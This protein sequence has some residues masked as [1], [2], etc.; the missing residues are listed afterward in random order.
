MKDSLQ[1]SLWRTCRALANYRR[2][3]LL[4]ILDQR[5][6]TTVSQ[7]AE[8]TGRPV[9]EISQGLRAL[10]ARGLL[11]VR[12]HW[13]NVYYRAGGDPTVPWA[14]EL[15]RA[16]TP[17]LRDG[18]DGML[19][20]FSALTSFTHYRRQQI[21]WALDEGRVLAELQR[22]VGASRPALR[23]HLRKLR[24]RGMVDYKRGLYRKAQPPDRLR[25]TMMSL[26][27]KHDETS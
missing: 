2:L 19:L 16:I 24:T 8:L 6:E 5:G 25:Q 1:P 26:A 11:K 17:V 9:S 13:R 23:R 22:K 14:A 15:L 18:E 10:N 7:M 27:M 3:R 12:R 20:A 4:Q 21:I